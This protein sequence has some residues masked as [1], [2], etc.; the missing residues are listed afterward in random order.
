MS[1]QKAGRKGSGAPVIEN[2]RARHDYAIEETVE[3]GIV[4]AGTEIKS[5]REGR[6]NL[7]ESFVRIERGEAW[8]YS[9]HIAPWQQAGAF[10]NHEPI[11]PRKLLLHEN[12]IMY[13]RGK[14]DQKGFTLVPLKLYFVRGR[15]KL[16]IALAKGKKLYDKRDA[17]AD[18]DAQRDAQREIA[19]AV[20]GRSGGER[21]DY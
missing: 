3:A 4:L 9:A 19:H 12:E 21:G 18:R 20:R 13:L 6:V 11:R 16:E 2:R 7:T 17:I 10:F 5:V 1:T 14:V 15:A 8:W